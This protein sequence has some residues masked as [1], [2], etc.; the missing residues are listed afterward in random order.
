[1]SNSKGKHVQKKNTITPFTLAAQAAKIKKSSINIDEATSSA[2]TESDNIVEDSANKNFINSS[3]KLKYPHLAKDNL[4]WNPMWK[5][6]YPWVD[7]VT[8]QNDKYMIC[9]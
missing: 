9:T 3:K 8:R 1:M 7:L 2:I 4:K 6:T 5:K